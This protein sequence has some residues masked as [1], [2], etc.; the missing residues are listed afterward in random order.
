MKGK[1][2]KRKKSTQSFKTIKEII[3]KIHKYATTTKNP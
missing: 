1:K 3:F 2:K